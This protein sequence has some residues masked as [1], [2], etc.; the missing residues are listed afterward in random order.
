[1]CG[2]VGVI[3]PAP[4]DPDR[5][6]RALDTLAHRGPDGRG[7]WWSPD[8]LIGLGH[9]RLAIND[10]EGGTQPLI[11]DRFAGVINGEFYELPDGYRDRSDNWALLDRLQTHSTE[12]SLSSLNGEFAGLVYDQISGSLTAFRDR[13]GVKPLYWGRLE[14][15][16]WFASKPIALWAAGLP[17]GWCETTFAQAAATQYPLPG[18]TLYRGIASVLPGHFVSVNQGTTESRRYWRLP[19]C[20]PSAGKE[21]DEFS[22][23]LSAAVEARVRRGHSTAVML[24]GGIDS[25]SVL[26][27]ASRTSEEVKAY[28][29]DFVD[30]TGTGFSEGEPAAAQARL[31]GVPHRVLPL[32]SGEILSLLPRVVPQLGGPVVNGHAVAKWK[33]CQAI[34][35]DGCKVVLSGEGADELLFG[36]RHFAPCFGLPVDAHTDPAGLGI[37]V[38]RQDG[39][40]LP[41]HWPAFFSSKYQLGKKIGRF[42][43][44]PLHSETAFEHI[45]QTSRGAT[46]RETARLAWVQTALTSY[47]LE[48]LSDGAEMAHSVEGRPPFLDHTLWETVSG[49]ALKD[50]HKSLL[51]RAMHNR[52]T[53]E[54]KD[55]PKHPFMAAPL[56]PPLWEA[57][58]ALVEECPHP[59]VDKTPARHTLEH[60]QGLP[61]TDRMEWEPA[62]LWLASTYYLQELWS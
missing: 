10:P 37:L 46:P 25:A 49:I 62:L 19:A 42:L 60:I 32:S 13:F 43:S 52:V 3:A 59:F 50:P 41:G 11:S 1:M 55:K 23:R 16:I 17:G 24:S 57:V 28:S 20:S 2:V 39:E 29:I 56:G 15:E 54:I 21:E 51:R 31:C 48:T 45:L 38:T 22:Q 27:L 6:S 61:P 14:N 40:C 33:L 5:L 58:Q 9:R 36:Y 53:P 44:L 8:R 30:Q 47:I 34:R 7:I 12:A 26:A 35:A 4:V 18:T